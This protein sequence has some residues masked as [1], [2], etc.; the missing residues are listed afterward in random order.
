MWT[1][2][3]GALAAVVT[4][5]LLLVAGCI[6]LWQAIEARNLRRA[7]SRPFVHFGLY[8]AAEVSSSEY[9]P[10]TFHPRRAASTRASFS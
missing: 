3:V 10:T 5:V 2:V 6:A 7:Q 8:E 1:D 9:V 4:V